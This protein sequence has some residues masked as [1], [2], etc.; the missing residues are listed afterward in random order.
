MVVFQMFAT[1]LLEPGDASRLWPALA[2][3]EANADPVRFEATVAPGV[4]VT[5]SDPDLALAVRNLLDNAVRYT[6]H[7]SVTAELGVRNGSAVFSVADT[8]PGI[9]GK[10]LPRIFERFYR[11][12]PARSRETGGT[13]LGLSIVRHVAERHGGEAKA[14]S[15]LG[16][17]SRFEITIPL[18][19]GTPPNGDTP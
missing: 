10:H 8:G 5:G 18:E 3:V 4:T 17:G 7:G 14:S 15:E 16:R 6:S 19:E 13:G 12:D 9:A 11:V 1:P 2:A